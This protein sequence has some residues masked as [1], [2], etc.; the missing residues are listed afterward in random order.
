VVQVLV[1]AAATG[2]GVEEMAA[3]TAAGFMV[4]RGSTNASRAAILHPTWSPL[5]QATTDT[6]K[7]HCD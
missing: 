6:R 1:I 7:L 3:V 4:G 2:G 5:N